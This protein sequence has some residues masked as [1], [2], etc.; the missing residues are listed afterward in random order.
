MTT[1]IH[2]ENTDECTNYNVYTKW[3]L[4]CVYTQ[5]S[6]KIH[7][8]NT[9]DWMNYTVYTNCKLHIVYIHDTTLKHAKI[10]SQKFTVYFQN[11]LSIHGVNSS[12][13]FFFTLCIVCFWKYTPNT[14]NIMWYT[15]WS[16]VKTHNITCVHVILRVYHVVKHRIWGG[17]SGTYPLFKVWNES[18]CFGSKFYFL[19]K[20]KLKR[21][22]QKKRKEVFRQ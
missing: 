17:L 18:N 5:I 4:H 21:G 3:K 8:Q 19:G 11:T 10:H 14:R 7:N 12:H 6:T 1:K 22:K 16:A 2:N 13:T 9:H 15:Q 20:R